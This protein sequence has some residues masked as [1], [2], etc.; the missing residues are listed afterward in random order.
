MSTLYDVIIIGGG[1][2][3]LSAALVLARCRRRVIVFDEGH[4][5]NARAKNLHGYLSRDGIPPLQLLEIGRA[6]I[7]EYGTELSDDKATA[8][9]K[10]SKSREFEHETGFEVSTESGRTAR[11]RKILFATGV[12]DEIPDIC[13]IHECYG[14]SVHHC[15]YCDGWEHRDQAIAVVGS[16]FEATAG[17][18]L[19]MHQWSERVTVLANGSAP[20]EEWLPRLA[21]Y[22]IAVR[23]PRVRELLHQQG[24]LTHVSLE[25]GTQVPAHALFF[26]TSHQ[27]RCDIAAS[28]GCEVKE[29]VAKTTDKQRTKVP[30]V[31]FAGDADGDVQFAIVAAAEG[32]TAAVT[33]NKELVQED[34][35]RDR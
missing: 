9:V 10:V 35:R 25:D 27:A 6:E 16:T 29:D 14:V 26:N 12:R 23:E 30:G 13:G 15:P 34:S 20:D 8:A 31:F 3:G 28:L 18:A 21:K 24:K 7:A 33:I 22:G 19:L 2:A 4:P 32:A 1:P 17:L 5:R 11:C